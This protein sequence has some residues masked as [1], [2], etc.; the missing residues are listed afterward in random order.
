MVCSGNH[1]AI[2]AASGQ[3]VLYNTITFEAVHVLRHGERVSAISFSHSCDRFVSSGFGTTKVWSVATGRIV[4]QIQNP[5]RTRG[6]KVAF[7][8]DDNSLLISSADRSIRITSLNVP[9][10]T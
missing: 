10:P 6:L 9:E 4:L 5:A 1:L 7:S 3:T 2:L 8:A